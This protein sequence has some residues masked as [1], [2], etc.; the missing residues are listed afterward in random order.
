MKIS[1]AKI[2][3]FIQKE[4]NWVDASSIAKAFDVSSRTIRNYIRQINRQYPDLID[5]SHKGYRINSQATHTIC[6]DIPQDDQKERR[7]HVMKRLVNSSSRISVYDLA[8]ELYISDSQFSRVLYDV[9]GY[10]ADF[11]LQIERK[12]NRIS[13]VGEEINKRKLI[14][15]LI[16]DESMS[17]FL[18]TNKPNDFLMDQ[19]FSEIK[20]YLQ[21]VIEKNNLYAN[22]YG[23]NTILVHVLIMILRVKNNNV[24]NRE[25]NDMSRK[26]NEGS[27]EYNAASDLNEI[28]FALYQFYLPSLDLYYLALIIS[29]NCF[30]RDIPII[31]IDNINTYVDKTHIEL[32]KRILKNLKENYCMDDFSVE[33]EVN[34][35]IHVSNLFSRL[36]NNIYTKNPLA[37]DFKEQYP[38]IYDM[39]T[40]VIKE[41][42]DYHQFQISDDEIAFIGYHI[43]SY[44]EKNSTLKQKLNCCFLYA[45]YHNIYLTALEKI[46]TQLTSLLVISS[47]VSVK[48][49]HQIPKGTELIISCAGK[50]VETDIPC[51]DISILVSQN[52]IHTIRRTAENI[53]LKKRKYL[54]K[55]IL[56]RFIGEQLFK[57]DLYFTDEFEMIEKIGAECIEMKLCDQDYIQGILEREKISSTSFK[58]GVAIPHSLKATAHHSF[59]YIISNSK[60][61]KWGDN[62]VNIIVMI[63]I[64][65]HDRQNFKT[66]FD[67]LI[68]LLYEIG[69]V[70][71]LTKCEDYS[72][73]INTLL[74]MMNEI[75]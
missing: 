4:N 29:N 32:T 61:M 47:V 58:N 46:N 44:L 25:L 22:D 21:Q 2:I 17:G 24:I 74:S 39:A 55:N 8:D 53:F 67:T 3:N 56:N 26:I 64:S 40:F 50:T 65:V 59:L 6:S 1:E 37:K 41:I 43:G 9:K 7:L 71:K 45:D 30:N 33:F 49:V 5:S 48:D 63:G 15:Y 68:Q 34:F 70:R 12:R 54:T 52:D 20:E 23:F 62:L 72:S 27:N 14:N 35:T 31:N 38:L 73:F 51:V 18:L 10:L 60:P 75:Y 28:V 36:S 19:H 66:I 42:H 69:N 16:T 13:L 11:H 57:K